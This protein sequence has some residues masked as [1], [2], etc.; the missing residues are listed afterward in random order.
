M[1]KTNKKKKFKT[2]KSISRRF[3][4]TKTGKVLRRGSH[5]RHLCRKK[6]KGQLRLQKKDK[7]IKGR[8]KRGVK[9]AL[10]K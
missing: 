4:I 8:L 3:K 6:T 5:V 10:G 2:K 9:K 1:K 7:E